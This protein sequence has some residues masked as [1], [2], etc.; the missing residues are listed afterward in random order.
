MKIDAKRC[1]EILMQQDNIKILCHR[2]PDGDTYGSAM[3][4][5]S[6]LTAMGKQVKV[7]CSSPF[8]ANLSFL[9]KEM[10]A[11]FE[12][13]FILAVDVAAPKMLLDP[14]EAR[15]HVDLCIDHHGTNPMYADNTFLVDYGSAG[16]AI[17]DVLTEMGAEIT[18]YIAT[19]LFTAMSSDTGGFRYSSTTSR[20]MRV[21]AELMDKGADFNGIRVA[22][23]E[24]KT[25]GQIQV[26]SLALSQAHY[27]A[28][29]RI[30]VIS[31]TI[32]MLEQAGID[33]SELEGLASKT[34]EILGVDIGITLKERDNGSIRVSVRST[35]AADSSAIC[36]EF[37]G[38]GH[39]RA[40]G[41]RI[42]DTIENAER[43]L[44]EVCLKQLETE[45]I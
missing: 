9:H 10:P 39:V 30:A 38:G 19:A 20:T 31:V 2:D 5:F 3:A 6:A 17:Y 45:N 22:L 33:E 25:R 4:L 32:P 42:F 16:E 37:E 11:E 41:C 34:I 43:R 7:E 35:K 8:P 26:E 15:P 23:F 28:G 1:A 29:G 24:S 40:S 18:P 21:A 27:Y 44:V 13:G 14:P 12:T 36:R